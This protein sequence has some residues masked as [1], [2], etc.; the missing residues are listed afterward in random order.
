MTDDCATSD[1]RV[2]VTGLGA[3]TPLG[4]SVDATWSALLA[5]KSGVRALTDDWA[6]E[7][8]VR[9]AAKSAVEPADLLSPVEVRRLDRASQFAILAAREAWADAG[10]PSADPVRLGVA[11]ST[12]L[13]GIGTLLTAYNTLTT[14]GAARVSPLTVPML[15]P[16]SP[17]AHIGLEI[18]ARAGV[19]TPVSACASGAEGV[20]Y[21]LDMIRRGRADVVVAGG[22]EAVIGSL[23]IAAFSAMKAMSTRNDE[24]ERASRP[25]DLGRDG[26]ILGE[27]AAVLVLESARHAEARG[28]KVY[29]EVAGAGLSSDSHHIAQPDP[30]GDGVARAI[31]FALRDGGLV[32]EQVVH[33]NAH[34]TSTNRGDLAEALAIRTALGPAA[35]QVVVSGIKSMTGHLLGGA[36]A[37]ESVATVLAL[38]HRTAPP[39]IN[40]E[41]LDE[42]VGLDVVRDV[43]RPL[44][45]GDIV[46]LNDSFGFGG[47]NVVV[48][49]RTR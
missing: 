34:A 40:V 45:D 12:G 42:R 44:P 31:E 9:I 43:P 36:G 20:A 7:L 5:G 18:G 11:V 22:T 28:A 47:H 35:G 26:F 27:G 25:F 39:T 17:A 8:T 3:V 14:R 37:L 23:L 48:A 38:H 46:A 4:A 19:H 2:V 6:Q 49:F 13:G 30:E 16:N 32:P 29:C 33:V 10:A 21:G 15:I 41:D 24:P 1:E